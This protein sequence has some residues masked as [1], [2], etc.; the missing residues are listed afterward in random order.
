MSKAEAPG[1]PYPGDPKRAE[2][3]PAQPDRALL[4]TLAK[5]PMHLGR[6]VTI[7]RAQGKL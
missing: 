5:L 1:H 6:S 2:A 3:R 4:A 7:P